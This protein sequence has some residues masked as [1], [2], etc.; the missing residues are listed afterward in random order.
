MA[1][2]QL[3]SPARRARDIYEDAM[4]HDLTINAMAVN[5]HDVANGRAARVID[6]TQ[7]GCG[8]LRPGVV[9]MVRPESFSDDPVRVLRALRF[10]HTLGYRIEPHHDGGG[11][12]LRAHA[13]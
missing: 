3:T 5:I 8:T 9:R 4:T 11:S 2:S 10:S 6:P 13:E 1:R 7:A 12:G